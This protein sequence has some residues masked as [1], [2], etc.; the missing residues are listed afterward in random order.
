[1]DHV[2]DKHRYVTQ[3]AISMGMG[4][5]KAQPL[6][7]ANKV[8]LPLHKNLHIAAHR[9]DVFAYPLLMGRRQVRAP[10]QQLYNKDLKP[11]GSIEGKDGHDIDFIIAVVETLKLG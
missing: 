1:M 9:D 8:P 6:M 3:I 10:R 2:V 5:I 7:L 11:K 4:G